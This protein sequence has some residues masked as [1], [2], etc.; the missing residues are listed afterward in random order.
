MI[1]VTMESNAGTATMMETEGTTHFEMVEQLAHKCSV[2]LEE[3][4]AAL[5]TANWNVLTATH[6]LEQEEFRRK[7]ELNTVLSDQ[8]ATST[9]QAADGS[10]GQSV[11][12]SQTEANEKSR[13]KTEGKNTMKRI[14]QTIMDLIRRGNRN[15]FVDEKGISRTRLNILASVY[16]AAPY[17]KKVEKLSFVNISL[18]KQIRDNPEIYTP[19]K[20]NELFMQYKD[21]LKTMIEDNDSKNG[22]SP[23]TV[24]KTYT[25]DIDLTSKELNS[26]L[27]VTLTTKGFI[28]TVST[29][30]NPVGPEDA[31][32]ELSNRNRAQFTYS[33]KTSALNVN[34]TGSNGNTC[35]VYCG[36]VRCSGKWSVRAGSS[37]RSGSMPL[38]PRRKPLVCRSR[39]SESSD[40]IYGNILTRC[41]FCSR[42]SRSFRRIH[43]FYS[44]A[45]SWDNIVTSSGKGI[46]VIQMK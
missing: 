1:N 28:Y 21:Q 2:T 20:V 12:D 18:S 32:I 3:A 43:L 40:M 30:G 31:T 4:K 45:G 7:Q 9:D 22:S 15:H 29:N 44:T 38:R 19:Q 14:G 42:I 35:L 39:R 23:F 36:A 33:Y 6:L 27:Q 37:L 17:D 11:T 26:E 10:T 46:T 41:P 16:G 8:D 5:E 24:A 34:G 13:K 25:G